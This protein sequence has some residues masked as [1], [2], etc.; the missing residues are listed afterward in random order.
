MQIAWPKFPDLVVNGSLWPDAE[1]AVYP[2]RRAIVEQRL[3]ELIASGELYLTELMNQDHRVVRAVGDVILGFSVGDG[4]GGFVKAA[5]IR[6]DIPLEVTEASVYVEALDRGCLVHRP[7]PDPEGKCRR[8]A[9]DAALGLTPGKQPIRYIDGMELF[10]DRRAGQA[11]L[12]RSPQP[13]RR[14][15][16]ID[17]GATEKR[18]SLRQAWLTLKEHGAY[19]RRAGDQ[20]SKELFWLYRE[21]GPIELRERETAR[22]KGGKR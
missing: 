11:R 22:A 12:S 17:L 10:T 21:V 13:Q 9:R 3:L 19:V 4:D 20:D 6:A 14:E 16:V 1:D 8:C 7:D 2:E 5:Q 15:R 18:L